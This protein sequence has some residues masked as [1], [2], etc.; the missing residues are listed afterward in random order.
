MVKGV[1]DLISTLFYQCHLMAN[2]IMPRN[3]KCSLS[4]HHV[5]LSLLISQILELALSMLFS[6]MIS[7]AKKFSV[8]PK[9]PPFPLVPIHTPAYI[10][11]FFSMASKCS[12]S[13]CSLHSFSTLS[14]VAFEDHDL[15]LNDSPIFGSIP[16]PL[17]SLIIVQVLVFPWHIH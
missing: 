1:I 16:Y 6:T 5:S 7:T 13:M 2:N 8:T 15:D 11:I 3:G 9:V 14:W 10:P 12:K 17:I 4:S